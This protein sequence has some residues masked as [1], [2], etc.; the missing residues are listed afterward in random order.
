MHGQ[1]ISI[2]FIHGIL[3]AKIPLF[4]SNNNLNIWFSQKVAFKVSILPRGLI[5]EHVQ[6][7]NLKKAQRPNTIYILSYG[8]R[9]N[10]SSTSHPGRHQ[11]NSKSLKTQ[12]SY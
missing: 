7:F 1:F 10:A 12:R 4:K 3:Y 11:K 8:R 5:E 6:T 2:Y 9:Q